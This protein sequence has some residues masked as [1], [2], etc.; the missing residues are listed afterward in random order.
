I[1]AEVTISVL[2]IHIS[3]IISCHDEINFHNGQAK[4]D[5]A[6][7]AEDRRS[8]FPVGAQAKQTAAATN[9]KNNTK[10]MPIV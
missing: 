3:A 1:F 2:V 10:K 7:P 4:F 8:T 9:A 5:F 6:N